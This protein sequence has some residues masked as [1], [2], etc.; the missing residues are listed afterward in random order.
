MLGAMEIGN[1]KESP[2]G[3][4]VFLRLDPDL[5]TWLDDLRKRTKS[6]GVATVVRHICKAAQKEGVTIRKGG[7]GSRHKAESEAVA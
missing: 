3:K 6:R 7:K 1:D 2:E 4:V 5:Y